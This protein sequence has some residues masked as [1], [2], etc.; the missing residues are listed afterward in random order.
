MDI[1]N[2]DI[3]DTFEQSV[4]EPASV[5]HNA[6]RSATE[7]ACLILSIDETVQNPESEQAQAQGGRP[8]PMGGMGGGT[9]GQ[10]MKGMMK[11]MKG[12]GMKTMK[13]MAGK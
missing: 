7:A 4:L 11:N 10:G 3:C 5:K 1:N 13:G 9:G 8:R 6:L 12:A 2:D